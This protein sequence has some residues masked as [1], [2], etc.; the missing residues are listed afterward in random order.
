MIEVKNVYK[1]YNKFQ[2]LKD[3]SLSVSS[4][5]VCG[6][7]GENSAGKT[8]LIK[9]MSGIY[10][11]DSGSITYDGEAVYNNP[12]VKEKV[13]YVADINDYIGFYTVSKMVYMYKTFYPAFE[14]EK[15]NYYNEKM[16]IPVNKRIL[17]LSKGQK[18]KLAF[19]LELSK[20]PDYLI[21]DEP[22]S[23]LDPVAKA[24]F[25][26]FLVQEVELHNTGVLISSH[27]LEGL[28]RICDSIV[29]MH[30][31][32]IEQQMSLE[33]MKEELV[34]LQVVFENGA[35]QG[36]NDMPEILAMHH[37]GSIYTLIVKNYDD[38]FIKKLYKAGAGFIE[39]IELS[40]EELFVA[41]K[42]NTR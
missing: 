17:S 40:L 32:T 35:P 8:T 38:A 27:N 33:E 22:T 16:Q 26:D 3:I 13:G 21:M 7:I 19:M 29:M 12:S 4:G 28:E 42:D 11:T 2:A 20:N 37:I 39:T 6:L 1:S 31:G 34:K 30:Q 25:Y 9:C 24:H 41:L 36:I 5:E 14:K 23:G 15:F 18:M 10:K